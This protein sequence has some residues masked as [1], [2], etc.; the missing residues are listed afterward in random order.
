MRIRF[1]RWG[2]SLAV[3]IPSTFAREIGAVKGKAAEIMVENG[4]LVIRPIDAQP[5]YRLED[6]V[7]GITEGSTYDEID[8]GPAVGNEFG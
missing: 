6:L 3:R 7:A 4:S 8:T 2:N 5:A 1:D